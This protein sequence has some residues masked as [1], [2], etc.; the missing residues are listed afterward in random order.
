MGQP[1]SAQSIYSWSRVLVEGR[2]QAMYSCE[3]NLDII[4]VMST[5]NFYLMP[6]S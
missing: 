3:V 5:F 2:M 6:K 4:V 1:T